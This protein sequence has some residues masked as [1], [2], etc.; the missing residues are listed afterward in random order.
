MP[1]LNFIETPGDVGQL[2]LS[3][4]G[5]DSQMSRPQKFEDKNVPD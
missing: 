2:L 4:V 5:R 3:Q 1:S